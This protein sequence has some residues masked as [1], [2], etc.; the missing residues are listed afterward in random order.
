MSAD[1]GDD[2]PY[3]LFDFLAAYKA[4]QVALAKLRPDDDDDSKS[5]EAVARLEFAHQKGLN[6]KQAWDAYQKAC[7]AKDQT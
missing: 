2:D 3:E 4:W 1:Y 6:T 5:D 7:D